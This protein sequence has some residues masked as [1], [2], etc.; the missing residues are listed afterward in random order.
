MTTKLQAVHEKTASKPITR[1]NQS[2][3]S[4]QKNT[5]QLDAKVESRTTKKLSDLAQYIDTQS[6]ATKQIFAKQNELEQSEPEQISVT[7]KQQTNPN[8]S[9]INLSESLDQAP[10]PSL[11]NK[12]A[13]SDTHALLDD[14]FL[15]QDK[16]P[17][18]HT[19][20]HSPHSA[21]SM[22]AGVED[23]A[24]ALTDPLYEKLAAEIAREYSRF[25]GE[26]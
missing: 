11:P 7:E 9:V 17:I 25:D 1:T 10:N 4:A 18:G 15:H 5:E 12:A 19:L 16:Q 14:D 20:H 26:N 21:D 6:V 2:V 24:T 22:R 8:D 13:S 3:L 23:V